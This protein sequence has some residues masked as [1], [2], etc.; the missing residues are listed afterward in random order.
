MASSGRYLESG[1]SFQMDIGAMEGLE[2]H[3]G[4]YFPHSFLVSAIQITKHT[5]STIM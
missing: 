1:F 3:F 2:T 4:P 5:V